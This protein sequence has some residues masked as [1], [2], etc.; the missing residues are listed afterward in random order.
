MQKIE[1]CFSGKGELEIVIPKIIHY[2]WFGK[3]QK[4]DLVNRCIDTWRKFCPDWE[5][6]EWNESNVDI[7]YSPYVR[8]AYESKK[9]AFVSD[10]VRL[11]VVLRF[12]GIYLDTDVELKAPIDELLIYD[13][14]FAYESNRNINTGIGFGAIKGHLYVAAMLKCY[15][16]KSFI[17]NGK[18]CVDPCP[19]LNTE[20]LLDVEKR[21]MRNGI[22][23]FIDNNYILS[24]E[25]YSNYAFHHE[26]KSWVAGE[27]WVR[28]KA[29]KDTR[30]KRYLRDS[31]R[32]EFVEKHF[33]KKIV[34]IYTFLV[35]D[36]LEVEKRYYIRRFINKL[37]EKNEYDKRMYL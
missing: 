29:Y 33:S 22:K 27:K 3:N 30:I 21:F 1:L 14:F 4:P 35:Y 16:N 17:I 36:F 37:K 28:K 7:N 23:Q 8:E 10:V 26:A 9:W 34:A 32:F 12:G 11:D 15:S 5:I 6:V 2:C 13:S 19:A 25:E 31:K 18:M 20:A 24:A